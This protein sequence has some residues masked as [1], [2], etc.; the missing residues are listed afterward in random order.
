MG[1]HARNLAVSAGASGGMVDQVAARMVA[2]KAIRADRAAEILA[3][4]S[5]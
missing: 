2:E 4:L 3:E 5:A 1:L